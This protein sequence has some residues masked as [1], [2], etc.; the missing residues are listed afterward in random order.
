MVIHHISLPP[1]RF[2][3]GHVEDFFLNRLDPAGDP[4]YPE[5]VDLRVS[6]HFLVDREGRVTQFVDTD[7]KA[8]HAGE[9]LLAG[10]PDVNRF[11]VGIELEGD[12]GSGYTEDQY[13]SLGR[14]LRDLAAGHPGIRPE[15]IVGH[16][17]VA[18][19][20]KCDPG[21]LFDWERVRAG[22]RGSGRPVG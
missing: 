22:L 7:R 20:R 9:S 1:G 19:G 15:R 17:D 8:W 18:P 12:E 16:E 4:F 10:V 14:L 5:I 11:S 2:G 3:S 6:A 21:A 13:A